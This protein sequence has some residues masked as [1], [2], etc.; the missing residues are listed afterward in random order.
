MELLVWWILPV[1]GYSDEWV[2][3]GAPGIFIVGL[4]RA[5]AAERAG[6]C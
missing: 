4:A 2:E 1:P 6:G 5:L 3:V